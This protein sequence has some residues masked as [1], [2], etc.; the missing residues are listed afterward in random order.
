MYK[1]SA[2]IYTCDCTPPDD[3]TPIIVDVLGNGYRLTDAAGGVDFDLDADGQAESL[4]WTAP[5]SDD[6]FLALDRNGNG[7]IDNGAELFGSHTAQ[8]AAWTPNGFAA[9]AVF[10]E[11]HDGL[12]NSAGPVFARLLLW[13]DENHDG[14]SQPRELYRSLSWV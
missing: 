3:E 4:S 9:L 14:A 11:N 12:I 6:S 7:R 10:D 1:R 8:P 5:N 2:D 13:R